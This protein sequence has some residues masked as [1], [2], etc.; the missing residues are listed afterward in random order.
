MA[1]SSPG[2]LVRPAVAPAG[3]HSV[4]ESMLHSAKNAESCLEDFRRRADRNG[5]RAIGN[6]LSRVAVESG[7]LLE[8][9]AAVR[10]PLSADAP[11]PANMSWVV[12]A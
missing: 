7:V 12:R 11:P 6:H 3:I 1:R 4:V 5:S 2:R 10:K 8:P 9:I